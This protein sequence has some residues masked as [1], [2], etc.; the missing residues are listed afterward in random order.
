MKARGL[1][2]ECSRD[3]MIAQLEPLNKYIDEEALDNS[4]SKVI[5]D[6]DVKFLF[7]PS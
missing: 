4:D 3:M 5:V 1:N 7:C 2:Y 6:D